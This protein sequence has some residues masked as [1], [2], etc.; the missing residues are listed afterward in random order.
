[1]KFTSD[2]YCELMLLVLVLFSLLQCVQLWFIVSV[3]G[4]F[5]KK[6]FEQKLKES[7]G[8]KDEDPAGNHT[9]G[10]SGLG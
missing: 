7:G 4:D 8:S 2:D 1:M 6:T 10:Q 9:S 3:L 5:D